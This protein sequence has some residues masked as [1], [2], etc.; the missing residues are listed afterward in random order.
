MGRR[1]VPR[2]RSKAYQATP[3][4]YKMGDRGQRR[5]RAGSYRAI[6]MQGQLAQVQNYMNMA[7]QE[8]G[9]DYNLEIHRL[10]FLQDE[11]ARLDD[12]IA[13]WN[14]DEVAAA[15]KR[16]ENWRKDRDFSHK[17]N[18]LQQ[19]IDTERTDNKLKARQEAEKDA[20]L[21]ES[22]KSSIAKIATS[23][24]TS[25]SMAEL[26]N[27]VITSG[28]FA[29]LAALEQPLQ[30]QQAAVSIEAALMAKMSG[31]ALAEGET[32]S[33]RRS[34]ALLTASKLTGVPSAQISQS[35]FAAARSAHIAMFER[36]NSYAGRL[37][38]MPGATP[39]EKEAALAAAEAQQKKSSDILK[40]WMDRRD[41]LA[42]QLDGGMPSAPTYE[43]VRSR[44]GEMYQPI[45]AEEARSGY[46]ERTQQDAQM[47][48]SIQSMPKDQRILMQASRN[49]QRAADG[50]IDAIGDLSDAETNAG[51]FI[52]EQL[53][54][55]T[56]SMN[57]LIPYATRIAEAEGLDDTE[58]VVSSRDRILSDAMAGL[59]VSYRSTLPAA[60]VSKSTNATNLEEA[61]TSTPEINQAEFEVMGPGGTEL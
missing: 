8:L 15:G 20:E 12:L 40:K 54:N 55:G 27:E 46:R 5:Q 38:A 2:S 28:E 3:L 56:L 39:E 30:R 61:P 16:D 9:N 10:G 1:R 41:K 19:K 47:R 23:S 7:S 32:M 21:S 13:G 18:Q 14:S 52:R 6:Y 29:G 36:E 26:T 59:M 43:E 48:E 25:Q 24:Y 17:R 22:A 33:D 44:A 49:G 50:D 34:S 11:M 57:D 31:M 4:S 51:A 35:Q 42:G 53:Q 45:T 37:G 58:K 60:D